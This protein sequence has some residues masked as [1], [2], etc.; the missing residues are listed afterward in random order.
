MHLELKKIG[1][2]KNFTTL[3]KLVD[4]SANIRK[5]NSSRVERFKFGKFLFLFQTRYSMSFNR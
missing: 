2:P 4:E 5:K 3:Q 1:P